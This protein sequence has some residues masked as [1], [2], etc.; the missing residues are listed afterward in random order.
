MLLHADIDLTK[1]L[2]LT[3][4]EDLRC[5]YRCSGWLYSLSLLCQI[6]HD[7]NSTVLDRCAFVDDPPN[8]NNTLR[9]P[10]FISKL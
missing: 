3:V 7:E 9:V 6:W 5:G 2:G 1:E 4:W 10:T 8:Y